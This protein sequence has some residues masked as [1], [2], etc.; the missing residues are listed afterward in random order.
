MTR[1]GADRGRLTVTPSKSLEFI[2]QTSTYILLSEF[3]E[4]QK[5]S[6]LEDNFTWGHILH[7]DLLDLHIVLEMES[8]I[9]A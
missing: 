2:T 6:R 3:S 7:A 9:R 5:L 8:Y 1:C 4:S